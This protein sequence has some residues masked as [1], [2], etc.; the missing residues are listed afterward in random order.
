MSQKESKYSISKIL[1]ALNNYFKDIFGENL[2]ITSVGRPIEELTDV[3]KT[4]YKFSLRRESGA[5]LGDLTIKEII[6]NGE[7]YYVASYEGYFVK[8][9]GNKIISIGHVDSK[10]ERDRDKYN[11]DELLKLNLK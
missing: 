5:I 8:K 1:P 3:E 2:Y 9:E 11:L 10:N 4:I 7:K 6:I